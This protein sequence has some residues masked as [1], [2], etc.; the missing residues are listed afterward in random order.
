MNAHH[1]FLVVVFCA[2][3]ENAKLVASLR[4]ASLKIASLAAHFE[5]IIAAN[6]FDDQRVE[7]FNRLTTQ[8][9]L[10]SSS[11]R[12]RTHQGIQC[13]HS[14]AW[15]SLENALPIYCCRWP[16]YSEWHYFDAWYDG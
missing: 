9:V 10:T 7:E 15:F 13:I 6:A 1:I 5:L 12:S 3:N 2:R 8:T 4:G 11:L 16:S 14:A